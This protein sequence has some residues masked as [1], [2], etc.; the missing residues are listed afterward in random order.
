M[1]G[2]RKRKLPSLKTKLYISRSYLPWN[3]CEVQFPTW[4]PVCFIHPAFRRWDLVEAMMR[5]AVARCCARAPDS[6]L[7]PGRRN[8]TA[9][10]RPQGSATPSPQ[11]SRRALFLSRRLCNNG[12]E[13]AGSPMASRT[14]RAGRSILPGAV[15][16]SGMEHVL[17]FRPS[18]CP[19]AF[20]LFLPV[21]AH[22]LPLAPARS[23]ALLP[24][25]IH[26][27][28]RARSSR[29]LSSFSKQFPTSRELSIGSDAPHVW[30]LSV[31]L[32]GRFTLQHWLSTFHLRLE[33]LLQSR[34][35]FVG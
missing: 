27:I 9:P 2:G 10:H 34:P 12:H 31:I 11:A 19:T 24:P 14:G 28:F 20:G 26:C 7:T 35:R 22:A 5:L 33:P 32:L 16:C 1:F 8:C 6:E 30:M 18:L 17:Y 3:I 29:L 23:V 21:P 15:T 4:Q 13:L 25:P